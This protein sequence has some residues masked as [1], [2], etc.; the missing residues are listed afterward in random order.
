MIFIRVLGGPVLVLN[1]LEVAN[2]LLDKR[3]GIYSSRP[4]G[5]MLRKL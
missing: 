1:S 3:G 2:D 4:D 5:V